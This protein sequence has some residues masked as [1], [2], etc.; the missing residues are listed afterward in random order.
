MITKEQSNFIKLVAVSAMLLDHL[1]VFLYPSIIELR[2]I[3]RIA[4][5]I[6][7][8][9]L[10]IGYAMTPSK[11]EYLARLI[12]F[13]LIAQV[14]YYFLMQKFELNILFALALGVLAL[15]AL[16]KRKYYYLILIVAASFFVKY[17]IYGLSIIL[18]FHVFKNRPAQFGLFTLA[19]ILFSLYSASSIQIF[20]VSALLFIIKPFLEVKLSRNFFYVFFPAHLLIILLIRIILEKGW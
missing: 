12:G 18:I 17:S 19:T 2:I 7:A 10:T 13:G 1:G 9:Q 6:F 8:Y 15:W 14:P 16:D 11:K 3:G 20:A 5:P 4:F